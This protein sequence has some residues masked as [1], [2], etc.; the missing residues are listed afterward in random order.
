MPNRLHQRLKEAD[1]EQEEVLAMKKK[2]EG[3]AL[4]M[5]KISD[6]H[7]QPQRRIRP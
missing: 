5:A 4:E 7:E 2:N 6:L 1:L 3:M